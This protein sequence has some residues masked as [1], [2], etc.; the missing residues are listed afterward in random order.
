MILLYSVPSILYYT[1]TENKTKKE[2]IPNARKNKA[3]RR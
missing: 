1:L 3:Q 2:E